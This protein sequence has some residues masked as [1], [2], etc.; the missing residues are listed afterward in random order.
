MPEKD[1]EGNNTETN[2]L[3]SVEREAADKEVTRD[4][5]HAV[6]TSAQ[7]KL[8]LQE[9]DLAGEQI[10]AASAE[11]WCRRAIALGKASSDTELARKLKKLTIQDEAHGKATALSGNKNAGDPLPANKS[12]KF[13]KKFDSIEK[14]LKDLSSRIPAKG[15]HPRVMAEK[16]FTSGNSKSMHMQR[17]ISRNLEGQEVRERQEA[18][19]KG[20]GK[21]EWEEGE[22]TREEVI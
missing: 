14:A 3:A 22:G 15:K 17:T 12:K 4:D 5:G 9:L 11:H 10:T 8:L 13:Q 6:I 20:Q 7:R 21:R 16:M 1:E 18:R 19:E 2:M